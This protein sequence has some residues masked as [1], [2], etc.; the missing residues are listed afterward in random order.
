MIENFILNEEDL[1]PLLNEWGLDVLIYDF[2]ENF[3]SSIMYI[4]HDISILLALWK[5]QLLEAYYNNCNQLR[6]A[7]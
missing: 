7:V 2:R 6:L 4:G 1:A 5:S 3:M